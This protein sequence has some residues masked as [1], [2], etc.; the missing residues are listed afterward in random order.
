MPER[1]L[2]LQ[3]IPPE[4]HTMAVRAFAE[5]DALG[6]MCRMDN[7]AGLE[8]VDNN[9][10]ALQERGIFEACLYHALTT[11]RTNLHHWQTADLQALV[12]QADK[13]KLLAV[14]DPLPGGEQFTICRGLSGRGPARHVSGPFW[15]ASLDAVLV[16]P[17]IR[18]RR[19]RGDLEARGGHLL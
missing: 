15:T 16:R 13:A 2:D 6:L 9:L 19:P 11:T 5:G 3:A 1:F 14:G 7:S 18:S 10:A 8:F 4:L 17:A 12:E